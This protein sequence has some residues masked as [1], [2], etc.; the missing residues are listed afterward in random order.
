MATSYGDTVNAFYLA[1]YGRPADPAGLAFWSAALQKNNGDFSNIVNAFATSPEATARF[2]SVSIADRVGEIYQQLFNRA[3]EKAGLDF[4]VEAIESGRLTMANAALE[5]MH[6][7]Q[8]TDAQVSAVR[9]QVA[10]QFTAEV[11]KSGI[12]YDGD[13]AVQ[14]ARVLISAVTADSKPAD[15]DALIKAGS[16]LVQTAHDNPA[17]ITALAN[18]GELSK[19]LSTASGQAD[20][21]GMVQALASIGKAAL[22]D[23]AGLTALLRGGGV[24][25]L[26]DSLPAGTSLKDVANAV[27]EGGMAA[28]VEAAKPAPVVPADTTPPAA[29]TVELVKDTG[30]SATDHFTSDGHVRISGIEANGNWEYSFDGTTWTTGPA[31]DAD[32]VAILATSANGAQTLQVRSHDLARNTSAVTTFDFTLQTTFKPTL[33]FRDGANGADLPGTSLLT[34]TDDY[35]VTLHGGLNAAKV[36]FQVSDSGQ[37]GTWADADPTAALADGTYYI[38]DIVTDR[39]GNVGTTN[40]LRVDMDKTAPATPTVELVQDTGAS[41][42][43][44]VT[45]NGKIQIGGIEAGAIVQ[46]S[47]DAGKT[48]TT[49]PAANADGVA[50]LDTSANG[51]QSLQV[52]AVDAAGNIGAATSFA[53]T[54]RT[55]LNPTMIFTVD[56][57]E[58]PGLD[59]LTVNSP[60]YLVHIFN[61]NGK[62]TSFDFQVSENGQDGSWTTVKDTDPLSEGLHYIRYVA[63]DLAGNVGATNPLK[64]VMDL[65][66]PAAPKVEL[67]QDTGVSPSD[68]FTSDGRIKVSG[69]E[70]NGNWEYSLDAGKTW[71]TGPAANADGVAILDTSANGPQSLQ[72]RSHDLGRNT[73]AVTTLEYTLQTTFKP[74]LAFRDG[75]NGADLPGTSL[76]TNTDDYWVTLH[77]GLNAAKVVFQVSDSGQDGTWTDGDPSA[78]LADGTYYIRDIVTDRA[79]NV[80]TTN[81]LRVDMDKTAPATPTVELV[82][83]TGISATDRFTSDGRVKVSGLEAKG[84]WEY[85]FDGTT[86]TTGPAADADGVAILA[87]SVN[88]PQTLQVRSHDAAHNTSATTTFDFTLQSTFSPYL[89]FRDGADGADLPGTALLTNTDNFWI[90]LHGGVG[91]AKV[92]FQVS[93]SGQDGTWA[94]A[95]M[96]APLADGTHYIRD[97]VTDRAGNTST[98]NAL[99]VDMDKTPPPAPTG[100]AI[101][102]DTGIDGDLVT[103]DGRFAVS[104]LQK[105]AIWQYSSDGKTWFQGGAVE[106]DGTATGYAQALRRADAAGPHPGP[107]R[108]HQQS[109]VAAFH[110]RE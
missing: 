38:R 63:T 11:E 96:A 80:G 101:V 93:D 27:N 8:N 109:G 37:D 105:D 43:D 68:N 35:W 59:T 72:V 3:P 49:G 71:T 58:V 23:S 108:E 32:G 95:D 74:T 91:A 33:A 83:D 64:L 13:A 94:D 40:A 99:R 76:L 25:A 7:A 88:G 90:T 81:A 12:A 54:L 18:G 4:W 61:S 85:S 107:G 70:A 47:V 67:V 106:A 9:Q 24:S 79:G 52:R 62:G 19:V 50:V 41:A 87:T 28:G 29:P 92:V 16:S 36:V 69:I 53:Y 2:A 57:K 97:I 45:S 51:D 55:A 1:Y 102:K 66:A 5:I 98:T 104:G 22:T 10:A 60:D 39:A 42:S 73:S 26:L 31:A 17:V 14:A 46:Y 84:S 56:G 30:I 44:N 65:T 21:V 110:A 103:T 82:Q 75:A 77:G 34:N 86:W 89:A 20:P 15:I 78:P 100:I 6:A 48:W